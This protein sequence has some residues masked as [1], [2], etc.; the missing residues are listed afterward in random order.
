M[1]VP[2]IFTPVVMDTSV[3]IDGGLLRNIAIGELKDMGATS[4]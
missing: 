4:L 3:L 1:A 2:S